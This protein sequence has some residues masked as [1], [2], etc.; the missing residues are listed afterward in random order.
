MVNSVVSDVLRPTNGSNN[1]RV[2]GLTYDDFTVQGVFNSSYSVV[3]TLDG[4]GISNLQI[5]PGFIYINEVEP[6]SGL[7]SIRFWPNAVGYQSFYIIYDAFSTESRFDYDILPNI[8]R[9]ASYD[10][11]YDV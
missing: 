7:Y 4:S 1:A 3:S 9:S 5:T 11:F 2:S 6:G 8:A 10:V